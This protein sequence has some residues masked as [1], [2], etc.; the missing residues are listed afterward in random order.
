MPRLGG[1]RLGALVEQIGGEGRDQVPI[2]A[3]RLPVLGAPGEVGAD[4][5]R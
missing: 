5:A 1:G 3:G 4:P 2:Q